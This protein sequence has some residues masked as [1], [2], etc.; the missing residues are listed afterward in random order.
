MKYLTTYKLFESKITD[1]KEHDEVLN[2]IGDILNDIEDDG[3]EVNYYINTNYTINIDIT[4]LNGLQFK[5]EDISSTI[6]HIDNYLCEYSYELVEIQY[7]REDGNSGGDC[8]SSS[9]GDMV[10][11]TILTGRQDHNLDMRITFGTKYEARSLKG[12][13]GGY[14]TDI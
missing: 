10:G 8:I 9:F 14:L 2:S 1:L 4:Y 13:S 11:E 6:E 5:W 12:G 3:F 7:E